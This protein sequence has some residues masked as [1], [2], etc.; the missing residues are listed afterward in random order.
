VAVVVVVVVVGGGRWQKSDARSAPGSR[1]LQCK[2]VGGTSGRVVRAYYKSCSGLGRRCRLCASVGPPHRPARDPC[3]QLHTIQYI[4]YRVAQADDVSAGVAFLGGD[5][6]RTNIQV[7]LPAVLRNL[8]GDSGQAF[9]LRRTPTETH[10]ACHPPQ[11]LFLLGA[12]FQPQDTALYSLPSC[13]LVYVA[14]RPPA[15]QSHEQILLGPATA[16]ICGT[17]ALLSSL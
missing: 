4:A 15:P 17:T 5:V 13:A 1:A 16:N 6:L 14:P 12:G 9:A 11:K 7:R 3:A 8:H 10:R 2:A